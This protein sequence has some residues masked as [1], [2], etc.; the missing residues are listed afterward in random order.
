M[1][2][3]GLSA[4]IISVVAFV[5]T[6]VSDHKVKVLNDRIAKLEKENSA[7]YNEVCKVGETDNRSE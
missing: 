7:L 3:W 4:A 2:D 6:Q 1:I 5:C